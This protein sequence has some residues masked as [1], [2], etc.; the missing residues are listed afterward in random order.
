[1]YGG[2][3][4]QDPRFQRQQLDDYSRDWGPIRGM[5]GEGDHSSRGHTGMRRITPK[6]Y[7]RSDERLRED[8][9]E[10][11]TYS[12]LDVSDV[13]VAVSDGTVLLEGTVGNRYVKHEIE[14]YADDC[15]GVHDVDNRIRVLRT[16]GAGAATE[17]EGRIGSQSH[18]QGDR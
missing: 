3:S 9:C 7:Q 16:G 5:R 4:N 2:F 13:Y 6:G 8:I 14:N 17:S 11:L 15:P 10:Q 18:N 12:G 1:S